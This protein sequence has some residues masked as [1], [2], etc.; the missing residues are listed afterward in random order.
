MRAISKDSGLMAEAVTTAW[1]L[2]KSKFVAGSIEKPPMLAMVGAFRASWMALARLG[3]VTRVGAVV[4]V[5][6]K[7]LVDVRGSVPLPVSVGASGGAW[8]A[9]GSKR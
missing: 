3:E 5:T 6:P 7:G 9:A 2:P 4:P 8:G 1:P